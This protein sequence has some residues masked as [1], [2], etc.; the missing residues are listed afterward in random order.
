MLIGALKQPDPVSEGRTMR[1][2]GFESD[3]HEDGIIL[4]CLQGLSLSEFGVVLWS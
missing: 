4:L 3:I 2:S 1:H